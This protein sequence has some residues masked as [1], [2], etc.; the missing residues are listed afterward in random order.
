MGRSILKS[1]QF[2]GCAVIQILIEPRRFFF[3]ALSKGWHQSPS[4][5]HRVQWDLHIRQFA[6]WKLS[7]RIKYSGHSL[8]QLFGDALHLSRT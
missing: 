7:L 4:F 3:G 5:L 1:W 6:F 8:C 2:Y